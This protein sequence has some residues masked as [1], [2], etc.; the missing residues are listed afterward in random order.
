MSAWQIQ[1]A[2]LQEILSEHNGQPNSILDADC[3]LV[4]PSLKKVAMA[5]APATVVVRSYVAEAPPRT[6]PGALR[7]CIRS[8]KGALVCE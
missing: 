8:T 1:A 3:V 2:V 4:F 7:R 5:L 6:P